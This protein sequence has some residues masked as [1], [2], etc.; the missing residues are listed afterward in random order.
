MTTFS[1]MWTYVSS[2]TG[3]LWKCWLQLLRVNGVR[4]D[5]GELAIIQSIHDL[6]YIRKDKPGLLQEMQ[7]L[8][9][10]LKVCKLNAVKIILKEFFLMQKK[11]VCL[12]GIQDLILA[13]A[14]TLGVFNIENHI[15][16][17]DWKGLV[18]FVPE[19]DS[20]SGR[21]ILNRTVDL[22]YNQKKKERE[23]P[24]NLAAYVKEAIQAAFRRLSGEE[25]QGKENK[26]VTP[27]V[28]KI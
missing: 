17:D 21:C 3:D 26:V 9:E 14:D 27:L 11:Y 19:L 6:H 4:K 8:I 16:E 18:A 1:S 12:I 28:C 10:D 7:Q 20:P 5:M 23:L 25:E 15:V 24:D 22:L 2:N 13:L